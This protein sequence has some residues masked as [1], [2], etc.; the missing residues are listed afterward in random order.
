VL[1]LGGW[2]RQARFTAV[3]WKYIGCGS[4]GWW[5]R[6]RRRCCS[7]SRLL[8]IV[9]VV[10]SACRLLARLRS[11]GMCA[12]TVSYGAQE[13]QSGVGTGVKMCYTGLD[14]W[15]VQ[16]IYLFSRTTDFQSVCNANQ[17]VHCVR[18][19]VLQVYCTRKVN[20][21]GWATCIPCR[22]AMFNFRCVIFI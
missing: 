7:R 18:R 4:I 8:I 12:Y 20:R 1:A 16:N 13:L 11:V 22:N 15:L 21:F 5:R 9:L 17:V 10:V 6:W 2:S 19:C 14:S 3:G